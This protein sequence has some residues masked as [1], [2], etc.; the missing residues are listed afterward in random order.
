MHLELVAVVAE[1]YD[2]GIEF[3]VQTLGFDLV[4]NSPSVT[5]D[6]LPSDGRSCTHPDLAPVCCSR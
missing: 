2:S 3:F 4:E 5:N 1:D 6:G